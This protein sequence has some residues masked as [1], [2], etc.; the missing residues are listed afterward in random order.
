VSEKAQKCGVIMGYYKLKKTKAARNLCERYEM[1]KKK[2]EKKNS[3]TEEDLHL[4]QSELRNSIGFFAAR[5]QDGRP[6]VGQISAAK[7]TDGVISYA[8]CQKN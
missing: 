8:W 7:D 3:S 6:T 4:H 5:R 1:Y 2:K